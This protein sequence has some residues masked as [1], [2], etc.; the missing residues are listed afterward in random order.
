MIR[1]NF[2]NWLLKEADWEGDPSNYGFSDVNKSCMTIDEFID[3]LNKQLE[4]YQT[5]EKER[6]RFPRHAELEPEKHRFPQYTSHDLTNITDPETNKI[7]K[8]TV[9][10]F[11][12]SITSMPATIFDEGEKSK[13]TNELD[14]NVFTVNTGI[15][16]LRAIVFDKEHQK[17]YSINTCKGAGSCIVDCYALKGFYVL[18]DG[19][20]RKLHQR[21]NLLV[22]D[23]KAYYSKAFYELQSVA[24]REIPQG[25]SLKIRWNDAGDWFSKTYYNIAVKITKELKKSKSRDVNGKEINFA[26]KIMSYGYTKQGDY[27]D[28]SKKH[29]ITMNFSMGAKQ[30]EIDKVNI[31]KA[32]MSVVVP[33]EV[34]KGILERHKKDEP[35]VYKSGMSQEVLRERVRQW[36]VK[37]GYIKP[38]EKLLYTN[39]IVR[40]PED[41]SPFWKGGQKYNVIVMPF[42]DSDVAA[43]RHDVHYTFLMQH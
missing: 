42:G 4:R 17:F 8:E 11:V 23:P 30:D 35:P 37:N 12:K 25:K 41:K 33:S 10:D 15:P 5:K 38:E 26:D 7:S 14:P 34:F 24:H 2:K 6:D 21:V 27:M 1:I 39:E 9:M 36:A 43:Y 16:A 22:N 29:G 18:S 40:I 3:G 13:H 28:L 32:K 19:K 31:S 20:N